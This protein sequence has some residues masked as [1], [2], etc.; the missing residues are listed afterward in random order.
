MWR[1]RAHPV[2]A[3]AAMLTGLVT[4][5]R[6]YTAYCPIY[7][8]A[9]IN[10]RRREEMPSQTMQTQDELVDQASEDS[11]PASDPPGWIGRTH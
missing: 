4:L 10:R 1:G 9:G 8:R 3:A 6:A 2:S 11:F 7:A 5:R